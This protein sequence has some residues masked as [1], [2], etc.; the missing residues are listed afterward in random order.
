MIQQIY[1]Q[2]LE[3]ILFS[4]NQYSDD[5]FANW[6]STVQ[7]AAADEHLPDSTPGAIASLLAYNPLIKGVFLADST[8]R[9]PMILYGLDREFPVEKIGNALQDS[10]ALVTRLRE[11]AESGFQKTAQLNI[12]PGAAPCVIFFVKHKNTQQLA[13]IFLDTELFISDMVGP[14]LQSIAQDQFILSAVKKD[15]NTLVYSTEDRRDSSQAVAEALTKDF[16]LFPDYAIGIRAKGETL[17]QIVRERTTTNLMLL[18]TLDV[19]LII[20]VVL[21]F[22]NLKKEVHLARNK[23]DFVSNVSHEIRTPLA[24]IS[25]FAETL[26][27]DRVPSEEKKKEYYRI[28]SKESQRLTGIVNKI[29]TFSQTEARQKKLHIESLNV[30]HELKDI[31]N[32]YSFHLRNKGFEYTLTGPDDIQIRADREALVE[33]VINLI[34]NAMKYS[35]DVKNITISSGREGNFGIVTVTDRGVGISK[36]DQKHI[37]DKFYRVPAGNL[38][39]T[40][41]TGLGLALVK[42][43]MESQNGKIMVAS[44]P[45]KGTAFTLYFQLD[46]N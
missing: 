21:V 34:D 39:R 43:L 42:E 6:M 17:Q 31:M 22:R 45:G 37:F 13:G 23:A 28:I 32:T 41:G 40:R 29:L 38:A 8:N 7:R 26:E 15:N 12:A 44:E 5:I 46:K 14:R 20:A 11:Y 4:V 2:Q 36:K 3:A 33:C 35:D 9:K 18:A 10:T 16:W 19:I 24:L 27:M 1:S 25:M 30:S